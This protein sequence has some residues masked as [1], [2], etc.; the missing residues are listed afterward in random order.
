MSTKTPPP[1][2]PA[3]GASAQQ[4]AVA[5]TMLDVYQKNFAALTAATATL[6]QSAATLFESQQEVFTSAV[7]QAGT[8]SCEAIA[9]RA[10]QSCPDAVARFKQALGTGLAN[11]Q[12]MSALT[13]TARRTAFATIQA[14]MAQLLQAG[15]TPG[16][17]PL[18]TLG[19]Q[20][21]GTPPPTPPAMATGQS[22][23]PS[24]AP[25]P[26]QSA[27]GAKTR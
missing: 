25:T 5:N 7:Q 12:Q 8:A 14:R 2:T 10:P 24:A 16:S 11:L 22:Q 3:S 13:E 23:P 18:A 27:P 9:A 1:P 17:L 6:S 4:Q 26:P 19:N 21:A 20:P 15:A